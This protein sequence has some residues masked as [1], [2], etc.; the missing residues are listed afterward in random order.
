[1]YEDI[2]PTDNDSVE[3][4]AKATVAQRERQIES[5][6][7]RARDSRIVE[8]IK[9]SQQALTGKRESEKQDIDPSQE[10]RDDEAQG[11]YT[12]NELLME[13]GA[14]MEAHEDVQE[15][16]YGGDMDSRTA[17]LWR[18]YRDR[19]KSGVAVPD[20]KQEHAIYA[21]VAS[22]AGL[23]G[24]YGDQTDYA[25]VQLEALD[26]RGAESDVNEGEQTPV[27][28]I[29]IGAS[30]AVDLESRTVTIPLKD[31]RHILVAA[32]PRQGKDST[33]CRLSGNLKDE[34]GYKWVSLYDDGRNENQMIQIP[35]DDPGIQDSL[36]SFS[37]EPK[38]YPTTVYVPAVNL[39]DDLPTNHEAFSIGVDQLTPD[40][41][42]RLAGIKPS[43]QTEQRISKALS[44]IQDGR[45]S[46]EEL[47]GKIQKYSE[48][49]TARISTGGDE[50]GE[51]HEYQMDEDGVLG[52]IVQSLTIAAGRGIIRDRGAETNIDMAEVLRD[53]DRV[54]ALNA[55][56]VDDSLKHLCVLIWLELIW[57]ARGENE[58]LPRIALEMREIKN[59]A[60]S[61]LG[62]VK[63]TSTARGLQQI[64]FL[65]SSQ[66]SARGIMMLGSVQKLT[67]FY[68]PIRTN[69]D[70]NILLKLGGEKIHDLQW[71]FSHEERNQLKGMQQGWGMIA[72]GGEQDNRP[73]K[74]YP[75]NFC[76][77]RCGLGE[78]DIS[79]RVRYGES[80]GW[81][82]ATGSERYDEWINGHGDRVS[83]DD[84]S[85][86]ARDWYLLPQDIEDHESVEDALSERMRDGMPE[87][88]MLYDPGE[89][90]DAVDMQLVSPGEG[91]EGG[92]L[93]DMDVPPG[94]EAWKEH[95]GKLDRW[96][97]AL[98]VI[99]EE[100]ISNYAELAE[101]T[102]TGKSTISD[103]MK[104]PFGS[105]V[106]KE[107][108]QYVLTGLG[109]DALQLDW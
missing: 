16:V 25:P 95:L 18:S 79:W 34:H 53:Q 78:Q 67:D 3:E 29:R 92:G 62:D 15:A 70:I 88:L 77:A 22:E 45:G 101:R 109:E 65:L 36:E 13:L 33:I 106:A 44:E 28:R 89:G 14:L 97:V 60:P 96:L 46:V 35:S 83:S 84:E 93:D 68:K 21:S 17:I 76:G 98:K 66:G 47:I 19:R 104:R 39:P 10:R 91:G 75:I 8:L 51:T 20:K 72:G 74:V 41:L 86:D 40:I 6:Q 27:A 11:S 23:I 58:D 12:A 99:D 63:Y 82:I 48:E 107:D 7:E 52:E 50:D 54:A 100:E 42:T 80:S 31:C 2:Q 69:M 32:N 81:R 85:L 90:V 71:S 43:E 26:V 61:K 9:Q 103:D 1:M 38:G 5:E 102:G 87:P 56:H 57:Q 55:N 59:L 24:S 30:D 94:L 49:T 4:V 108:G 73:Q 64:L 37:Q 105:C